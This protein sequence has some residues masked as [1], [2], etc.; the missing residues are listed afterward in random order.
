[1]KASKLI[2]SL[3]IGVTFLSC[4]KGEGLV[5]HP[6]PKIFIPSN[7]LSINKAWALE[8]GEYNLNLQ[9]YCSGMIKGVESDVKINYKIDPSLI[10]EYNNDITQEFS[11]LIEELPSDCYRIE[12]ETV[13]IQKG[14]IAGNIPIKIFVNRLIERGLS[15]NELKYVIPIRLENTSTYEIHESSKMISSLF[16]IVIDN[17]NFYFWINKSGLNPVGIRELYQEKAK[18]YSY[19]IKA[20][21]VPLNSDYE[22]KV[23]VDPTFL[24]ASQ[25]L[26]Q[27]DAYKIESDIVNIEKEKTTTQLYISIISN[28][29]DFQK[30]YYLPVRITSSSK[31]QPHPD[32][33]VLLLKVE[34]KNDYE[35]PYVS[36][37][38]I[39]DKGTG[40]NNSYQV[41]KAPIS[42]AKDIIKLQMITNGTIAGSS[43]NNKFFNLKIIPGDNKNKW[44]V[45]LIKI[46]DEG[47]YNS[48]SS[49]ELNPNKESYYDWDYETFYLFY[50][51]KKSNGSL[52]EVEEILEA[53]F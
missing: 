22:L 33:S 44:G 50:R 26:M 52:V 27:S 43:F 37:L 24:N 49:L 1:M 10:I 14:E 6:S 11:G 4:N 15:V 17:P 36:K 32:K 51:F 29:L 35:W 7:G 12:S 25:L 46:T 42:I 20:D 53:Q 28:K 19:I 5:N 31:Y 13:Q 18:K 21:G 16:G 3:I 34:I 41:N 40:R 23:A 47:S 30:I 9:V 2:F 39:L 45:E 8:G 48:P 38:S